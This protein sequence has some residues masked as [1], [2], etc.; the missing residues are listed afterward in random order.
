VAP[1][2]DRVA[3]IR[4]PPPVVIDNRYDAGSD[5]WVAA[6]DGSKS[7]AVYTHDT[8]NQ[9]VRFPQWLDDATLLAVIQVIDQEGGVTSVTYTL[10]RIDVATGA[11]ERILDDVVSFTVAPDGSRIVYAKLSTQTGETLA[12]VGLD[13]SDPATLVPVEEN[14]APF[15]FPRFSPDGSRIAFASADQTLAPPTPSGRLA[16]FPSGGP[17]HS[18]ML[19]GLP[20]DIWTVDAAG[21]SRPVLVA[22]LKEDVPALTWNGDGSHIYVLGS[23]AL[24]DVNMENGAVDEIAPGA[25]HGQIDWAP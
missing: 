4:Q 21:G 23:R 2:G 7:H 9:L 11:R 13:G 14:L 20:E 6:R 3:Y 19:D 15:N 5:L 8:P 16:S 10:Q 22:E 24:F 1:A 25:F 18:A 17:A 12:A